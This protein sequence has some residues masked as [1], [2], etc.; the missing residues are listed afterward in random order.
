[1]EN[2]ISKTSFLVFLIVLSY[3]L[4]SKSLSCS[5]SGTITGT[6]PPAGHCNI[7]NDSD[8]CNQGQ[9]RL[10][11]LYMVVQWRLKMPKNIRITA[12]GKRVD[13]MVVDE[14]DSSMGC[15]SSDHDY[16]PLCRNNIVDGSKAVWEALGVDPNQDELNI[17]WTD[18]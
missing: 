11:Y 12:N 18:V 16:Q 4:Q 1:M 8:C 14:C 10:H 13:A 9:D 17:S 3:S 15:D 6:T 5:S 2:F 7:E